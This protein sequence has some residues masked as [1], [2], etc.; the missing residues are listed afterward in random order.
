MT[1]LE[2]IGSSN[3]GQPAIADCS[4]MTATTAAFNPEAGHYVHY[5]WGSTP[6]MASYK[7]LGSTAAGYDS[8]R[9]SPFA[10]VRV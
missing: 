7:I 1:S 4:F 2:H 8:D 6:N 10:T 3:N 9:F 5:S